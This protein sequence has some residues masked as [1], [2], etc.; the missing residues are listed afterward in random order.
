MPDGSQTTE[1]GAGA[2]APHQR[3]RGAAAVALSARD[4]RTR[5]DR[6]AQAG[7]AKAFLPRSHTADPEVVFLNTSGGLTGGDRLDVA[8]DLGAGARAFAT[9]QTAE[10]AYASLGPVA[11][12][13]V[14]LSLGSGAQLVWA[15]QETILYERSALS[16]R[17]IAE[18]AEDA[19]L[20]LSEIVVFGRA[21]MGERVAAAT[22]SDTREIRRGGRILVLEP[23][24][25]GPGWM[26]GRDR[27]TRLDRAQAMAVLWMV[28]PGVGDRLPA[29]RR[30][31]PAPSHA[32]TVGVSAW[33]G[34]LCLRAVARDV[35]ALR[36]C[37][38]QVVGELSG[39]PLPR[40]WQL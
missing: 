28:G 10:R 16:R 2:R 21:A 27:A 33:D 34:R 9:T 17:T 18:M 1:I 26:A 4:G 5:L 22:L 35:L 8:L 6:L 13:E 19:T 32:L 24:R 39:A 31:L 3:S 30:L 23:L 7:S 36:R 40:V 11:E 15:P 29:L 20:I 12:V 37:V 25:M 14:R 38:G